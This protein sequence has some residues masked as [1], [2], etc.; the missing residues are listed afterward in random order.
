MTG[1]TPPKLPVV[2]LLGVSQYCTKRNGEEYCLQW[3]DAA[4]H[5]SPVTRQRSTKAS[6]PVV[7]AC[8]QTSGKG[9]PLCGHSG[10]LP[11]GWHIWPWP[12]CCFP[13]FTCICSDTYPCS[14]ANSVGVRLGLWQAGSGMSAVRKCTKVPRHACAAKEASIMNMGRPGTHCLRCK[15]WL[16]VVW[17]E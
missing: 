3:V 2:H 9:R 12:V 1:C 17:H 7:L 10:I 15:G 16:N 4:G 13:N 6:K 8:P 14:H 11:F 5:Q